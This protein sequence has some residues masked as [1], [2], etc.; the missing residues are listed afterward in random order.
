MV[1][2]NLSQG[3]DIWANHTQLH[4]NTLVERTEDLET[5]D[6]SSN[7]LKVFRQVPENFL[8]FSI[9][10]ISHRGHFSFCLK[11]LSLVQPDELFH[12]DSYD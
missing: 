9:E 6:S 2:E 7:F 4:T 1:K 11:G 8:P 10:L 12:Y 5:E 3:C